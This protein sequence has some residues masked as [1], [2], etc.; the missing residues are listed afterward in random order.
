MATKSSIEWT[1]MTWNPVTGCTKVSQG[2]KFCYAERMAK[3][4][5]AMGAKRYRNGF[6]LTL[7]EDLIDLPSK[8]KKPQ[9]IFVNSMSDPFHKDVPTDY[10]RRVFESMQN[11]P[12]HTFQVLTK[13]S[14]RLKEL[15]PDLPWPENVWMGVSVEDERVTSRIDELRAVP[16]AVRFLSCEPLIGPLDNLLLNG[17]NWVIVG[18]E[19]GPGARPMK[20]EWATSILAQCRK[21]NVPFFF[22][23]WGGVRKDLSGGLL[24]GRIYDEMP[25][26][27]VAVS[28]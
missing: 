10:I 28:I 11:A 6:N 24:N 26:A 12:Q 27:K 4:L 20:Q 16:A 5:K 25:R 21:A 7:Q 22:K 9:V 13:R 19:S 8:I 1:E 18:G 2:C 14:Q 23:Q 15:A 17:I 3:R